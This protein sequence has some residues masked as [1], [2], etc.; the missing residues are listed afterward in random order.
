V[1]NKAADLAFL[2]LGCAA[3]LAV[4]TLSNLQLVDDAYISFRYA[5]NLASGQGLVFNPGEYV[6]GYTNLL[7]TL[8]MVVPELLNIPLY[9]FAAYAGALFG[10]L[11]LIET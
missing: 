8:L 9:L 7:W 4:L 10:V 3:A 5:H 11:A 6:E 2:L 1:K